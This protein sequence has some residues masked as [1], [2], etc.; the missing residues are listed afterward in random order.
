[1]NA[2]V[3]RLDLSVWHYHYTSWKP[4]FLGSDMNASGKE[5]IVNEAKGIVFK[6][7]IDDSAQPSGM[8]RNTRLP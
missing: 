5:T 1:M 8:Y 3:V 6:I 2:S 7:Q 4:Q